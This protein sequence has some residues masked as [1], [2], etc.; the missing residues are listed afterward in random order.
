M[1]V[2]ALQYAMAWRDP[3]ANRQLLDQTLQRLATDYDLIVLPEMWST[4]FTMEPA[5]VA[6]PMD[7]PSVEAMMGWAQAYHCNVLGSLIISEDGRFYNRLISALPDGTLHLYDKQKLFSYA[8]END[9]YTA[10]NH[11]MIYEYRGWR[12]CPLICYD[13]R[14]PRLSDRADYDVLIYT[15]NW[16][17]TRAHHWNTLLRA[18]AIENQSYVIA[19][20]RAGIDGNDHQYLGDSQVLD[21]Q[22]ERIDEEQ[23]T[24]SDEIVL[25]TSAILDIA[26]QKTYR[27]KLPFL[28]DK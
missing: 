9:Q 15:A 24:H 14:F 8:G 26:Q 23:A 18:R 3:L 21:F 17:S 5:Q 7:G 2:G 11:T 28:L 25:M 10:G 27:D 12:I 6:E 16:P 13:L 4:G 19:C 20:N 22:G 1:Q